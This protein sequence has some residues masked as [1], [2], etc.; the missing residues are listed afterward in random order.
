MCLFSQNIISFHSVPVFLQILDL[1]AYLQV[2][3]IMHFTVCDLFC[4]RTQAI[5][6]ERELDS[7]A[8]AQT[9]QDWSQRTDFRWSSHQGKYSNTQ[10]WMV[11]F[12]ASSWTSLCIYITQI[13]TV[14]DINNL[15]ISNY[16]K[17][18]KLALCQALNQMC[19]YRLCM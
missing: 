7:K 3:I 4:S 19:K 10:R 12:A 16:W 6:Q 13:T 11:K 9:I 1:C 17:G 18:G 14:L 2:C 8:W 15:M 5:S